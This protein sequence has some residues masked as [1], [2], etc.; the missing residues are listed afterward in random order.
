MKCKI[1]VKHLFEK[2]D[3]IGPVRNYSRLKAGWTDVIHGILQ[4]QTDIPCIYSFERHRFIED[5]FN[6][7]AKCVECDG[8]MEIASINKRSELLLQFEIGEKEH[9]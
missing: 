2:V 7:S 5:E 4:Q 6:W 3:M 8:K 1:P 9:T